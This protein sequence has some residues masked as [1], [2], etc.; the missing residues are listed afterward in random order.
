MLKERKGLNTDSF[1]KVKFKFLE[2]VD[3]FHSTDSTIQSGILLKRNHS[4]R[5]SSLSGYICKS[6]NL[7]HHETILAKMIGLLHDIG[8]FDQITRY[9]TFDD[10]RS[11][12]H[13]KFG[14]ELLRRLGF[15]MELDPSVQDTIFFCV[16]HHNKQ[17]IPLETNN[18]NLLH[19]KIVRD[20][21]KLDIM[22]IQLKEQNDMAY[23]MFTKGEN[24]ID[25]KVSDSVL[26]SF[27]NREIVGYDNMQKDIDRQLLM[28]AWV[29]D[30]NFSISYCLL[31]N[32]QYLK[33]IK[34]VL[35]D[36][37]EIDLIFNLVDEYV[38]QKLLSYKSL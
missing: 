27:V 10:R 34:N 37:D 18:S 30:L 21:D 5:V 16:L 23:S 36:T 35:A 38:D 25:V 17:A 15:L 11:F 6:L 4:L 32:R 7:N 29:Y 9:G 8:R 20:A 19:A 13:G 28:V 2:F 1:Q 12:D 33:K 31:K 26:A 24:E 14:T 3:S 22:H